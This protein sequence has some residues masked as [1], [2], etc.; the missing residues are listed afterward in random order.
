MRSDLYTRVVLTIIAACL[1]W[2]S[3]GGPA[4]LTTAQAQSPRGGS[5]ERVVISGWVDSYGKVHTLSDPE[6]ASVPGLPVAVVWGK[7]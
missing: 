3:L 1:V 5:D 7:R 2:L 4:V 6:K